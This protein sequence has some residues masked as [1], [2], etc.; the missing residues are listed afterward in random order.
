M[1]A[2]IHLPSYYIW[3]AKNLAAGN[4]TNIQVYLKEVGAISFS[5]NREMFGSMLGWVDVPQGSC[6]TL[7][8]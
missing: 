2:K 5:E 6:I 7:K 8:L 3:F 4:V 1:Y